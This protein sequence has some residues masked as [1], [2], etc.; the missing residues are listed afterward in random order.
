MIQLGANRSSRERESTDGT[1]WTER[2]LAELRAE[3][4]R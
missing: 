2:K 1:T 4:V 3:F